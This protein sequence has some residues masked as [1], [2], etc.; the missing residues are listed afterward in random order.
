MNNKR[1]IDA[2]RAPKY[3][4]QEREFI[5]KHASKGVRWLIPRMNRTR[6]SIQRVAFKLGVSLKELNPKRTWTD[7]RR[8]MFVAKKKIP[9]AHKKM[10]TPDRIAQESV[11]F[12]Q[13]NLWRV[14]D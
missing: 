2:A 11:K 6:H 8:K 12:M 9:K 13:E 10:S 1:W 4:D 14:Q 7:K 3:T 5:R